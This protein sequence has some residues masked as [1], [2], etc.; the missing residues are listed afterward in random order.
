MLGRDITDVSK[1]TTSRKRPLGQ[2]VKQ[3]NPS[4]RVDQTDMN[5]RRKRS[6]AINVCRKLKG[7]LSIYV[8]KLGE[9]KFQSNDLDLELDV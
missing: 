2:N 1:R 4:L 8:K 5:R 7:V 6:S 9:S 3:T